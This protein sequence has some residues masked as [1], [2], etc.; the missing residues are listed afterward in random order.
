MEQ[1][2][3]G[4]YWEEEE[5]KTVRDEVYIES[6]YIHVTSF[7]NPTFVHISYGAYM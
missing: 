1:K 2:Q 7:L 5:L 4:I 6:L 3:I